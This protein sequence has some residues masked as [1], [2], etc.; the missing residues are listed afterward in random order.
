MNIEICYADAKGATR[1]AIEVDEGATLGEALDASRVIERLSLNR[2]DL[3]FGIFGKR[4][5]ADA[6]LHDGDR[7]EIYRPLTVD[8]KEARR[9]RVEKK[10]VE[11]ERSSSKKIK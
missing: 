9:R 11:A 6:R 4:A 1:V 10:R 8:P 2:E 3:S 7:V 5:D